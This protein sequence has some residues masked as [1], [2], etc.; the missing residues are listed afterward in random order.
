MHGY[1]LT[2]EDCSQAYLQSKSSL[3]R[4]VYLRVPTKFLPLFES[5]AKHANVA[6][7][8]QRDAFSNPKYFIV[9]VLLPLYGLVESGTH[10]YTTFAS[11]LCSFLNLQRAAVDPCLLFQAQGIMGLVVDDSI[12]AGSPEFLE[13]QRAVMSQFQTSGVKKTPYKFNGTTFKIQ[14]NQLL[15]HQTPYI[16]AR[17]GKLSLQA[18]C[19]K[20]SVADAFRILRGQLMWLATNTRPDMLFTVAAVARVTA[21]TEKDL[22]SLCSRLLRLHQNYVAGAVLGLRYNRID[23][24]GRVVVFTDAARSVHDAA[25]ESP[26]MVSQLAYVVWFLA[27]DNTAHLLAASSA[28]SKRQTNSVIA[29]ETFAFSSGFQAGVM[30][31]ELL[32]ELLPCRP[33]LDILTDSKSLVDTLSATSITRELTLMSHVA[34]LREAFSL[35]E[36]DR[37]GHVTGLTNYADA[38]TKHVPSAP[39]WTHFYS[40]GCL[41]FDVT[42][43]VSPIATSSQEET[44]TSVAAAPA[45]PAEGRA[46]PQA[47]RLPRLSGGNP[48]GQGGSEAER[49]ADKYPEVVQK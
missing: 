5:S 48:G 3:T 44:G 6:N 30:C 7:F 15:L 8:P 37:V 33:A 16:L 19:A 12:S 41:Q 40:T 32:A 36:I 39:S 2:F 27:D 43:W 24:R 29:A 42:H 1:E 14:N 9:H 17:F 13:R 11:T 10:W 31:R 34:Y 49:V 46:A 35:G 20:H 25:S 38:L 26:Q 23:T 28:K 4:D 47:R 21:P 18:L 45:G 22:R